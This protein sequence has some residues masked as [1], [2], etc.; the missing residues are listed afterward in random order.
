VESAQ[1]EL[2]NLG[3]DPDEILKEQTQLA[4]KEKKPTKKG[5]KSKEVVKQMNSF[6]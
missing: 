4:Q 1:F 6:E 5:R 2:N 3:K